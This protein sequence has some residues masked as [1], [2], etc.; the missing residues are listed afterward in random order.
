MTSLSFFIPGEV[1]AQG[2]KKHVGRGVLVDMNKNLQPWRDSIAWAAQEAGRVAL[3]KLLGRDID[4][5]DW[6]LYTGPVQ[7]ALSAA[8]T[9]PKSHYGTGKNATVLKDS[10]PSWKTS[11][12]DSDKV[13]RA[14]LDA[15]TA[16]GIWRDDAQVVELHVLKFYSDKPGLEVWVEE[17]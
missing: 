7:V 10:A 9:R 16:S 13:A 6:P 5:T 3:L 17:Q 14:A 12:P 15:L 4:H 11:A 2:S 8:Y 1:S